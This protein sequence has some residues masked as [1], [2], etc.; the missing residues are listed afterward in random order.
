MAGRAKQIVAQGIQKPAESKLFRFFQWNDFHLHESAK[1][2]PFPAPPGW[3]DR[4]NWAN[5]AAAGLDPLIAKPDFIASVGD[6]TDGAVDDQFADFTYFKQQSLPRLKVPFLPC[7][8]NHE[9]DGGEGDPK[10]NRGYDLCFGEGWHDYIY[11]CAGVGFIVIDSSSGELAPC[12]LTARRAAFFERAIKRLAPMPVFVL[13]HIPLIAV[14]DDEALLLSFGANNY[15]VADTSLLD[16]IRAHQSR[17]IAV[18]SGHLHI[19]AIVPRDGITHVVPAGT[20][21]YPADLGIVDVFHDRVEFTMQSVPDK[22]LPPRNLGDIHGKDRHDIDYTDAQHPDHEQ[23][24]RGNPAERKLT[25]PMPV[26]KPDPN[27]PRELEVWHEA[28]NGDW[29]RAQTP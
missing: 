27:A 5:R 2:H 11:I 21:G 7:L 23:Y 10:K 16:A 24:L 13:T 12:P 20:W 19:T 28:A 14:R 29:V 1:Q 25:L 15:K 17:V 3:E 26:A 18:L 4:A 6:I 8:G 9:N 22:L